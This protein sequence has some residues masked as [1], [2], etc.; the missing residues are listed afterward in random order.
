MFFDSVSQ[1]NRIGAVMIGHVMLVLQIFD[2]VS[3]GN[4]IGAVMSGH[5]MLA[6]QIFVERFLGQQDQCGHNCSCYVGAADFSTAFPSATGSV[7]S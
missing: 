3:Q 6:L 1:G 2:S 4:R 7:W 5:V